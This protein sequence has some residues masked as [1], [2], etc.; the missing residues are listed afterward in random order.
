VKY[1]GIDRAAD[2]VVYR[3]FAQQPWR[4]VFVVARTSGDPEALAALLG[5]E[6]AAVDRAI[7]IAD[8]ST[9]DAVLAD[10][11]S[12]P[13]F[14]TLLLCVFAGMA[15]AIAA[16]GLYGVIAS[17]VSQRTREIGVRMALGADRRRIRMMV[18]REGA[19][20]AVLGGAVGAVAAYGM[21]RLLAHLLYGI[22]PNDPTS[23][24]LATAGVMVVGLGASYIPARR[25][26]RADPLAAIRSE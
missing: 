9:L 19:R 3:P 18:L 2:A 16:V 22:A 10:V 23:F 21:S 24:A 4:S 20:L 1:S 14:R 25:A 8:V 26:S 7:T 17:S 6:I 11:T 15:I 12:Q 13:R 5:R